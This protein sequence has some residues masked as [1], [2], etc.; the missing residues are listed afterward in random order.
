MRFIAFDLETTGFVAGVDQIVEIG[1]VRFVDGQVESVFATLIDP[2]ISVP[3]AASRVNG[4]TDL[5]LK[6]QPKI[7][8][9]LDPFAQFCGDDLLVAHNAPFDCQFMTADYKKFEMTAPRGLVLDT[10]AM[11]RNIFRGLANYK[12]GTL[13]QY[14]QIE[15]AG[16]HRAEADANYCGQLFHKMHT[17]LA[18]SNSHS[19]ESMIKLT[20]KPEFRFPII[21]RKPKQMGFLDML[22]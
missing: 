17:R 19:L 22:I 9:I 18:D 8:A 4:I 5:M 2:Q 14:L 13:V 10:C 16:F 12:L 11:A 21:E 7:D 6:G 15:A 1:A 3:E 20:S